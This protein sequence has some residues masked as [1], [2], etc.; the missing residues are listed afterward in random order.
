M[1]KRIA[2]KIMKNKEMVKYSDRQIEKA[3]KFL[4]KAKPK[5]TPESKAN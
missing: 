4:D 5:E 3:Q 1:K 2:K